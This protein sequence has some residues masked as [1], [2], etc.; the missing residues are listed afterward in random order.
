MNHIPT[1]CALGVVLGLASCTYCDSEKEKS[2][3]IA[4]S[5]FDAFNRH[6]WVDMSMHYKDTAQFLDPS[7]GPAYVKKSRED[8][9]NKYAEFQQA[10]PNLHDQV[11]AIH[12]AGNVAT[13]EFISTGT[14]N[15]GY[16][17]KIPIVSVL[18]IEHGLIT[19]DA[20]Y[21]DQP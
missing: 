21:Y 4:Q 3:K 12:V 11:V 6:D 15:E 10:F 8:I 7:F 2:Q 14:S 17:F 13:V 16:E 5:M 20:T 18:T 19:K 1:S 9:I